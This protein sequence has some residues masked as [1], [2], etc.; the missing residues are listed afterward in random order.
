M[1]SKENT[2]EIIKTSLILFLITAVSAGLLAVVNNITAPIIA[3][4]NALNQKTAMS[5]VLP[6][7]DNFETDGNGFKN[8]LTD[9]MDKSITAVYKSTNN[10][11]YVVMASPNGYGGAVSMAVGISSDGKVTGVSIISQSETPGLGANCEKDEFLK[12]YSGKTSGI[13]VAKG[14]AKDNQI[15]AISS[16]TIT[17]KAVT[18][19]VNAA[20]DAA[21][22][23][24]EEN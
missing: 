14:N 24:R 15:N 13:T 22:L 23:A 6:D 20:V 7:A 5:E 1:L 18:S 9:K 17:S 2:F 4:N 19:G 3:E 21:K 16:A 10:T 11:G 12:Q 8:Y